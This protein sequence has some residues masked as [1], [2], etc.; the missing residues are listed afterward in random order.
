MCLQAH[1][2][3]PSGLTLSR[4]PYS[5]LPSLGDVVLLVPILIIDGQ[6]SIVVQYFTTEYH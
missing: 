4:P 2:F 6:Q 3:R 1:A 5:F